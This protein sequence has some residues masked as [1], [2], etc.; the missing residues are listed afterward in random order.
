MIK[1]QAAKGKILED[2]KE[3]EEELSLSNIHKF[4]K[5]GRLDQ[6]KEQKE[7][8]TKE[9]LNRKYLEEDYSSS[10]EEEQKITNIQ[11]KKTIG[12]RKPK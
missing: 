9:T 10:S 3:Y 7:K 4:Q 6:S 2:E 12:G 11:E 8:I 5:V 1:V